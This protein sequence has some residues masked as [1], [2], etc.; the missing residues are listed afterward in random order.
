MAQ[1]EETSRPPIASTRTAAPARRA[2]RWPLLRRL[3]ACADAAAVTAAALAVGTAGSLLDAAVVAAILP[4]WLVL[5]KLLGLYDHEQRS[6]RYQT[7]DELP[8]LV[9]W[10][11]AGTAAAS[12][13][14]LVVAGRSLGAPNA[15]A[16][17]VSAW[18]A[19]A[20][21]RSAA[22][23]GW[24]RLTPPERAVVVGSATEAADVTR[25]LA[26]FA[27]I[28]V[29]VAD[30]RPQISREDLRHPEPSLAEA[31]RIVVATH[32]ADRELLGE[33]LAYCRRR[34]VRLSLVPPMRDLFGSAA[35]LDR[36]AD[37]PLV[38]YGTWQVARSTQLLK[39]SLDVAICVVTCLA[40]LPAFAL[41]A[42]AILLDDGRPIFFTQLRAGR[43]GEPFRMLKFR[44]MVPGAERLLDG[45]VP[46]DRLPEPVFKLRNDPRVTRAGRFL[47][48]WSLDELPQ[49]V[50]VLRGEMSLVGP[51]PE[52]VELVSRYDAEHRQRLAVRPGLTGPMQVF[53]RASL[54]HDERLALE[55]DYIDTLSLRR[56]LR[57]LALTLAA[58]VS[59]R[60]AY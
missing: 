11:A 39:R 17:G 15:I 4:L 1:L 10:A 22:R 2:R 53:G 25:K 12:L 21:L 33:L 7:L 50:N 45:L 55:L 16:A 60:G 47:R 5:A 31:D 9:T 29:E 37:L 57:I 54:R 51:R 35:R 32:L 59:G 49:L 8:A 52:Q 19:G 34:Q 18:A 6:L 41:I 23:F 20:V 3:L 56:D 26:H 58:I 24:R 27:A 30:V 14:E 42:L 40:L 13:V 28:H 36:I 46:F 38:E 44:T 48:R 43:R